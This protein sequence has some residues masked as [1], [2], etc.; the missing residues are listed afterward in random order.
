MVSEAT[1]V[2]ICT[3]AGLVSVPTFPRSVAVL[4]CCG[5]VEK[6][7]KGLLVSTAIAMLLVGLVQWSLKEADACTRLFTLGVPSMELCMLEKKAK[8][9]AIPL[10]RPRPN[11]GYDLAYDQPDNLTIDEAQRR[12]IGSKTL[13]TVIDG[14]MGVPEGATLAT[15]NMQTRSEKTV[16]GWVQ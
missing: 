6:E 9:V 3:A 16:V 2:I 12:A 14:V 7:V 11:H 13:F 10:P 15:L 8:L 5:Y 1:T 4:P